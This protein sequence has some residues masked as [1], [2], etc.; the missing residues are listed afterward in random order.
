MCWLKRKTKLFMVA[1]GT[2]VFPEQKEK[3]VQ[4]NTKIMKNVHLLNFISVCFFY[5]R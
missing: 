5:I 3:K 1:F 4:K 2:Y